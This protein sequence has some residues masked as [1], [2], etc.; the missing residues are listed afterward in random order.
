[1]WGLDPCF[2]GRIS[3]SVI[4]PSSF[5]SPNR[6]VSWLDH[7][8]SP[9]TCLSMA[10][11]YILNC[12]TTVLLVFRSFSERVVLCVAAVLVCSWEE[13]SSVFLLCYLDSS[14]LSFHLLHNDLIL[15]HKPTLSSLDPLFSPYHFAAYNTLVYYA[16][17]SL[18]CYYW[19]YLFLYHFHQ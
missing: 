12:R 16:I 8:S 4:S 14:F 5:R 18:L 10:L 1:M 3:K 9:P 19:F 13:M 15:K 17:T 11:F 6:G 7:S 2:L